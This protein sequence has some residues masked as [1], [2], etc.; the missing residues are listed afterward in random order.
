MLQ[1]FAVQRKL[2]DKKATKRHVTKR[3]IDVCKHW[4]AH[5]PDNEIRGLDIK[6]TATEL[7][8]LKRVPLV[9]ENISELINTT[10]PYEVT[11]NHRTTAL[12]LTGSR[13]KQFFR[14][15]NCTDFK[16][17]YI[18]W[19]MNR[20]SNWGMKNAIYI[21]LKKMMTSKKKQQRCLDPIRWHTQFS[22]FRIFTA[23]S[24]E[25]IYLWMASMIYPKTEYQT[26]SPDI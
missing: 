4:N 9:A 11:G 13:N 6:K 26:F 8:I 25:K 23:E 3:R 18:I 19:C 1:H 22:L 17:I 2:D 12:Q 24:T 21:F 5:Y 20:R 10:V 15:N 7:P 16:S 14:T